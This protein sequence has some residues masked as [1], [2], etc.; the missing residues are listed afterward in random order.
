MYFSHHW[1]QNDFFWVFSEFTLFVFPLLFLQ[2]YHYAG[3]ND[4]EDED[5]DDY[6]KVGGKFFL[7]FCALTGYKF[8]ND[9]LR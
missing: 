6:E 2:G 3:S 4:D 8:Q 7:F 9:D 1:N 5:P